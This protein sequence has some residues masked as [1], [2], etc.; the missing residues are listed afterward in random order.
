M[1]MHHSDPWSDETYMKLWN[2]FR[3]CCYNTG[4]LHP[5]S[6]L[7]AHVLSEDESKFRQ[8][9]ADES[10]CDVASM[11]GGA[12]YRSWDPV[13]MQTIFSTALLGGP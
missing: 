13:L 10:V 6:G 11:S 9:V 5:D 7:C 12:A 3:L 2:K 1:P 8:V 4:W